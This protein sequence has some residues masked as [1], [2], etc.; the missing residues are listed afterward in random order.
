[1]FYKV[2]SENSESLENF[3]DFQDFSGL[4]VLDK[5]LSILPYF[6]IRLKTGNIGQKYWVAVL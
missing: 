5:M 2:G 4:M 1:M 6:A 3:R